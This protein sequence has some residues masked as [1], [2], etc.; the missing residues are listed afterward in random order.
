VGTAPT[1]PDT[2][3]EYFDRFAAP[4][5][6]EWLV[7]TT[8]VTDPRYWNGDFITSSHFRKERDGSRWDPSP[9]RN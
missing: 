7:V 2:L 4:G 1:R 8:V 9:C 6:D 3:T 5:G